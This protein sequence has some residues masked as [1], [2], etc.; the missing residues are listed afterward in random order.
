[1]DDGSGDAVRTPTGPVADTPSPGRLNPVIWCDSKATLS[2]DINALMAAPAEAQESPTPIPSRKSMSS[3]STISEL[4]AA[5]GESSVAIAAP[6]ARMLTYAGLCSQVAR[7]VDLLNG[8]GVGRNERVAIVLPN[9]PE[10]AVAFVATAAGATA[11]PLNPAYRAEEFEFYLSDLRAK[12]LIIELGS[13]S[14]AASVAARLGIRVLELKP[15]PGLGAGTFELASAP[16]D[17]GA[18]TRAGS[19]RQRTSR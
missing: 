1:M 5:G 19:Q 7:I 17:P 18:S 15:T 16:K 3:D 6:D 12:A 13:Q 2:A 8:F 10:M 14:P 4:L 11:A 9:G